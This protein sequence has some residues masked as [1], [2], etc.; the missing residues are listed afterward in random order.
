MILPSLVV[1]HKLLAYEVTSVSVLLHSELVAT[2]EAK[3][4]K[5]KNLDQEYA[6]PTALERDEPEDGPWPKFDLNGLVA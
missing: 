2:L 4:Q 6:A 5:I 1:A 3:V